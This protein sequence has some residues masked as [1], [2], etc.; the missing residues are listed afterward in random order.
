MTIIMH[1]F[2]WAPMMCQLLSRPTQMLLQMKKLKLREVKYIGQDHITHR[3]CNRDSSHFKK[4]TLF[5]LNC[6]HVRE[7]YTYRTDHVCFIC[8][9]NVSY[10][11][12]IPLPFTSTI[13]VGRNYTNFSSIM[14]TQR[15]AWIQKG[16]PSSIFPVYQV[17]C[18]RIKH[19][20]IEGL[21][22]DIRFFKMKWN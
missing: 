12:S 5:P 20:C 6:Y 4:P 2:Y 13:S 15:H 1:I 8:T 21:H 16:N 11:D 22:V 9:E 3:S 17:D 19:C 18:F 7:S 10:L 14:L